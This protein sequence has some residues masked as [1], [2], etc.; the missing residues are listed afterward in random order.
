MFHVHQAFF[1]KEK[2]L[3]NFAKILVADPETIME[4]LPG[5]FK[6]VD[7]L[8]VEQEDID[9]VTSGVTVIMFVIDE[10]GATIANCGDCRAILGFRP[11]KSRHLRPE[12]RS[13][14]VAEC[15]VF[16]PRFFRALL[17][18]CDSRQRS[19]SL[20]VMSLMMHVWFV[21]RRCR[22]ITHCGLHRSAP[23]VSKP[24]L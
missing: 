19:N 1:V 4:E 12:V 7:G 5:I 18:L 2:L 10:D 13:W 23:A 8:L 6:R 20:L 15:V 14:A 17:R 24:A 22:W 21:S 16:S 3:F 9:V 11:P